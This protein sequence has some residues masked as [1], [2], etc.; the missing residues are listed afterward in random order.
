MRGTSCVDINRRTTQ[1]MRVT[2][3]VERHVLILILE[4]LKTCALRYAW[5]VL[6]CASAFLFEMAGSCQAFPAG[7]AAPKADLLA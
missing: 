4:Q 7:A 2:L 1:N 5:N 3:C 6:C